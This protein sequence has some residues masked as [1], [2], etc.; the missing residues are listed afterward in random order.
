QAKREQIHAGEEYVGSL[1]TYWQSR[2]TLE[3]ILHG[4]RSEIE[5]ID[6][7]NAPW[8]TSKKPNGGAHS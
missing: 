8:K 4:G 5:R 2:A 3:Q 1:K 6:S 7:M